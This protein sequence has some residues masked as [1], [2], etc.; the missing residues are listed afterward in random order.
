MVDLAI[1]QTLSARIELAKAKNDIDKVFPMAEIAKDDFNWGKIA[2]ARSYASELL[3]IAERIRS[4]DDGD[5]FKN[6]IT[7]HN[8][9][10]VLGRIAL[11]DNRREDAKNYLLKAGL[12]PASPTLNS[13]GPNMSLANDL[14]NVGERETVL[15]Y[16]HECHR[17][18]D[19]NKEKLNSWE[20]DVRD[21]NAPDFGANMVY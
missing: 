7:I 15:M 2:E 14:L 13:F 9:N 1:T 21:G 4:K 18:W 16:F 6:G 11:R 10:M 5:S 17:F 3:L 19:F 12:T 8:G 20:Q